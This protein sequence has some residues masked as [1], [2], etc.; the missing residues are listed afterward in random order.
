MLLQIFLDPF[1]SYRPFRLP[2]VYFCLLSWTMPFASH[3]L[4]FFLQV[5]N[6]VQNCTRESNQSPIRTLSRNFVPIIPCS[7]SHA[8]VHARAH[9]CAHLCTFAAPSQPMPALVCQIGLLEPQPKLSR[10]PS[11]D[12][13]EHHDVDHGKN[14]YGPQQH[15]LWTGVHRSCMDHGPGQSQLGPSKPVT[16]TFVRL[17]RVSR[18]YW[19]NLLREDNIALYEYNSFSQLSNTASLGQKFEQCCQ[20]IA[21]I[22]R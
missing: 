20:L 14:S 5:L 7:M 9:S 21:A 17:G 10:V 12:A 22:G 15:P 2:L 19:W 16:C 18:F 8:C 13:P 3:C 4:I 11:Q 6:P 1:G